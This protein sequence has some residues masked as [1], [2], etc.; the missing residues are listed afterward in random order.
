MNDEY[1][2]YTIRIPA[3]AFTDEAGNLNLVQSSFEFIHDKTPPAVLEI[4]ASTDQDDVVNILNTE[5]DS[6]DAYMAQVSEYHRDYSGVYGND[7]KGTGHARSTINSDQAW[8][9][10]TNL[11]VSPN[12]ETQM[13]GTWMSLF[14]DDTT[15][16]YGVAIQGRGTSRSQLVTKMSVFVDETL[17]VSNFLCVMFERLK[18][19]LVSLTNSRFLEREREL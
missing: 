11:P 2:N 9:A 4:R 13:S 17:V 16:I 3:N 8:S 7:A 10:P 15:W 18:R 5:F 6:E 12:L 14:L 19:S 1:T